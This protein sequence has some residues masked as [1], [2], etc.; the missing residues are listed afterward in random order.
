[1]DRLNNLLPRPSR[2][3]RQGYAPLLQDE[4]EPDDILESNLSEPNPENTEDV[5]E[6]LDL[7]KLLNET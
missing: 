2:Q 1:M 4:N 6:P 3:S 5:D 7:R